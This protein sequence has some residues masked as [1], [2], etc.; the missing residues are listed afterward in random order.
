MLSVQLKLFF[1]LAKAI[2]SIWSSLCVCHTFLCFFSSLSLSKNAVVCWTLDVQNISSD[3]FILLPITCI[4]WIQIHSSKYDKYRQNS[5]LSTF[6]CLFVSVWACFS[7]QK[8]VFLSA[9]SSRRIWR[10]TWASQAFPTKCTESQWSGA[11]SSPWWLWVRKHILCIDWCIDFDLLY[12]LRY[13]ACKY[14]TC[15][16]VSDTWWIQCAL[17]SLWPLEDHFLSNFEHL[18]VWDYILD[19]WSKHC[20]DNHT[21]SRGWM[22][23]ISHPVHLEKC[24]GFLV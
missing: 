20:L 5:T 13:A 3:V 8:S 21:G 14:Q 19:I 7:D 17:Q 10:D 2:S 24:K 9:F 4:S 11:L 18:P 23:V 16:K 12:N 15:N 22:A 6:I 1:W